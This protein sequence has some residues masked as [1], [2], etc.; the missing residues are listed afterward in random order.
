MK[1]RKERGYWN[2]VAAFYAARRLA[3]RE[4]REV[5]EDQISCLYASLFRRERAHFL[6]FAHASPEEQIRLMTL[7]GGGSVTTF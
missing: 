3:R 4:A 5:R 7:R 2:S 1:D 6:Y